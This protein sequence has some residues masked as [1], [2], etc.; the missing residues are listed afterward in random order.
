M[1]LCCLN[2]SGYAREILSA[3]PNAL[4]V[5]DVVLGELSEDS[6]S[7]RRDAE[8]FSA[9]ADAGLVRIVNVDNLERGIFERLVTG[10]SIDTLDDGEA[11]TIAYAVETGAT[12]IIDERKANKICRTSYPQLALG[13]TV[14]I[15]CHDRVRKVL[16][17]VVLGQAV[18]NAMQGARMRVLPRYLD[19][20]VGIVGRER[21]AICESL[22]RSVRISNV[23]EKR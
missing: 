13:C 22:P 9:L 3:I 4:L 1:S 6:R 10:R 8:L 20:V 11:A 17:D 18:F 21:A 14:D 12:A 15:F 5:T 7:G 2:A 19:W 16:G 23:N